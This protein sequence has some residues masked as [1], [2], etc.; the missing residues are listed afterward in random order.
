[1]IAAM[2]YKMNINKYLNRINYTGTLSPTIENLYQLQKVHLLNIPFENLDIHYG[3]PINLSLSK[4]YGKIVTKRRG[5]FCYELN[6]LFNSLLK[7]LGYNSKIIS[8]KVYDDKKN[9]FGREYDHLAILVA[10]DKAEY[11]VDVGFGEFTMNPLKIVLGYI[12]E[13][14][15]GDFIIDQFENGYFGV[16]NLNNNAKTAQYIFK[17]EAR[18]LSEFSGMCNYHQTSPDSHFT[19]KKLISKLTETGRITLTGNTLKITEGKDILW[20]EKFNEEEFETYLK[21]YFDVYI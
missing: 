11:L 9:S 13:D 10:L 6:G 3:H 14:P 20:E 21:K 1:M 7:V 17:K 5:G 19:Q 16:C 18:K 12:N 15:R 2:K 4:F 8:A